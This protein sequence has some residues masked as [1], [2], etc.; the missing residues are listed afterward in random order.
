MYSRFVTV[1]SDS[2]NGLTSTF[3]TTTGSPSFRSGLTMYITSGAVPPGTATMPL[4]GAVCGV[5]AGAMLVV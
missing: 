4:A 3:F 2:Q 1:L 5:S